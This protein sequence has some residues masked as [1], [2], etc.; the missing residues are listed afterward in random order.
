MSNNY[1]EAIES[2]LKGCKHA[3]MVGHFNPDGD[4]IGSVTAFY[5]YL[6]SRNIPSSIVIPNKYPQYLSF[7]D[8]EDNPIIIYFENKGEALKTLEEADVIICLDFNKLARTEWLQETILKSPAKKILIDHHPF[9]EGEPFDVVVS[10]TDTSSA[11]ELLYW[12]LLAMPDVQGD[13]SNLTM[14]CA[15]S[16]YV[17]MMTDTN[18]FSNSVIP[19]TFTM[20]SELIKRGVDKNAVQENVFNCYSQ[21]RMRLMGHLLKDNLHIIPECNAAF[22][23]LS[24]K[25]KK[26]YD[27]ELG[28]SEGFVNLP[29]SIK[30]IKMSA[31]FA[32]IEEAPVPTIRVSLRSKGDWDVNRFAQLYCNGGGHVNASGGRLYMPFEEVSEFFVKSLKEYLCGK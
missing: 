20:A 21:G 13:A 23:T 10:T 22:I 25:E 3:V 16:L 27:F 12:T 11:C 1:I 17:G 9:P 4:S 28:D 24:A 18:N 14:E 2:I 15:T 7:L 5:H 26:E 32:E 6:T 30:K 31:I 29:L 8:V 19:S